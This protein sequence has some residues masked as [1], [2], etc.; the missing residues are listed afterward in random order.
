[1]PLER[2]SA[3]LGGLAAHRAVCELRDV[4][5]VQARIDAPGD[6][7]SVGQWS[8]SRVRRSSAEV[9]LAPHGLGNLRG[10]AV[11]QLQLLDRA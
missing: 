4:V 8:R 7:S 3:E 1:M 5:R 11:L 2:E 9:K 6:E 10:L